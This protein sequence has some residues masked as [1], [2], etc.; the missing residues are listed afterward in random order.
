MK[1]NENEPLLNTD[2]DIKQIHFIKK[3][4]QE[5][6]PTVQSL[7]YQMMGI[8]TDLT[9]VSAVNLQA[10]PFKP[11][12]RKANFTTRPGGNVPGFKKKCDKI[13]LTIYMLAQ[14]QKGGCHVACLCGG[15]SWVD[16]P[17]QKQTNTAG[18]YGT[19]K[20]MQ[21]KPST[22]AETKVRTCWDGGPNQTSCQKGRANRKIPFGHTL[23]LPTVSL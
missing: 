8:Y 10:H 13:G 15:E 21:T 20:T 3:F 1:S 2:Y 7:N 6:A 5:L 17:P 22:S 19:G 14:Y 4:I 16:L 12:D 9:N 23:S 11:Q 18:L